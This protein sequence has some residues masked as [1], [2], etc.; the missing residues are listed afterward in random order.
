MADPSFALRKAIHAQSRPMRRS[1]PSS[2]PA[3]STTRSRA[4]GSH[5]MS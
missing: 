4:G 1:F 2:A 3:A 5:P